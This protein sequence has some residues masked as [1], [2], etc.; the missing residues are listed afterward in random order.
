MLHCLISCHLEQFGGVLFVGRQINLWTKCT[1]GSLSRDINTLKYRTHCPMN[2][3]YL[4]YQTENSGP[5]VVVVA[6]DKLY[7]F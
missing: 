6:L 5:S 1:F 3:K 2:I 4:A 7:N